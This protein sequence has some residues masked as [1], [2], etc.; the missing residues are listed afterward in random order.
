MS[1][2]EIIKQERSRIPA[3]EA[4]CV[5]VDGNVN[6]GAVM[7]T[8]AGLHQISEQ[9]GTAADLQLGFTD[10]LLKEHT[11]YTCDPVSFRND[12]TLKQLLGAI[13]TWRSD[14]ASHLAALD[15]PSPR[16]AEIVQN[17]RGDI[18]RAETLIRNDLAF[19]VRN[20]AVFLDK[21]IGTREGFLA[22]AT[23]TVN[24]LDARLKTGDDASAEIAECNQAFGQLGRQ[25]ESILPMLCALSQKHPQLIR[26]ISPSLTGIQ[27]N[28]TF[29][30]LVT[31]S[32]MLRLQAAA[33]QRPDGS[34]PFTPELRQAY[35]NA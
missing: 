16:P 35:S 27:L 32:I 31:S 7:H 28:E 13:E 17:L 29:N 18:A 2:L 30:N 20:K 6:E 4:Y 21:Q 11:Q 19:F 12:K 34:V 10:V 24:A 14:A 3:K 8:L 26:Q 25:M 15:A 9:S 5:Y 33:A 1:W 23:R 22:A